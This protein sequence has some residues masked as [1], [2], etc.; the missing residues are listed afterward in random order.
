MKEKRKTTRKSKNRMNFLLI[1]LF[2]IILP[3]MFNTPLLSIFN[4]TDQDNN[5]KNPMEDSFL[6]TSSSSLPNADYF[7][8]YKVITIDHTKVNGPGNHTNFPVL[9]SILD[10]DLDDKAQSDGDDIAFANSTAWLDHE[11]E[12][13]DPIYSGTEAQL[14]AWVR[15]P[16]LSTTNDTTIFMFYGNDTMGPR[17]NPTRVWDSN[18]KGVWHFKEDPGPGGSGDIKV[19]LLMVF[20]EPLS[21]WNLV[22]L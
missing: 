4:T 19:Q 15:I 10:S 22:I 2:T 1:I 5:K 18:Y 20:T 21:K 12:L 7:S 13:Y 8:N 16:L 11:I 14:I 9:I 17:E 3:M 6:S